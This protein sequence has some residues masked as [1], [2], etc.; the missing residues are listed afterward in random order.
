MAFGPLKRGPQVDDPRKHQFK[1]RCNTAE[2]ETIDRYA[3]D[4][5]ELPA[6]KIPAGTKKSEFARLALGLD[7][8]VQTEPGKNAL[9]ELTRRVRKA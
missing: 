1:I 3:R 4:G 5:V 9:D 2:L 7:E 6:R 8:P